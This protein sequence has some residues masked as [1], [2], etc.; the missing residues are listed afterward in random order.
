MKCRSFF[1]LFSAA[2]LVAGTLTPAF[3]Q[4][5]YPQYASGDRDY[6]RSDSYRGGDASRRWD[7]FLDDSSNHDFAR[8]FRA[9]PNIIHDRE[10]MS[11]WTGVRDLFNNHP[12][13]R[14][15][16]HQLASDYDRNT[17]PGEKWHRLM[18]ANPD[19]ASRYRQD[20][21]IVADSNLRNDEPEIREFIKTNPDVRPY[22]ENR[23]SRSYNRDYRD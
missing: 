3:A 22:L 7:R 4:Y 11:Q 1:T 6:G 12:E 5:R 23:A 13:V 16:V 9:N 8:I 17:R 21:S 10:Y 2:I 14:D 19:F 18:D 15:Y 20:P